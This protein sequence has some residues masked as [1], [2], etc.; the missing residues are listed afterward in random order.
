M[1]LMAVPQD[2]LDL[3]RDPA[4]AQLDQLLTNGGIGHVH[5]VTRPEF[6]VHD[7]A[8]QPSI[9]RVPYL[10]VCLEPFDAVL[11]PADRLTLAHADT[12]LYA[13][14][15]F[16]CFAL[17]ASQL[18]RLTF[19]TDY[20][21]LGKYIAPDL[22]LFLLEEAP[23]LLLQRLLEFTIGDTERTPLEM[24]SALN[25]IL[26][27][28]LQVLRGGPANGDRAKRS[29]LAVRSFLDHHY[30]SP[31]NRVTVARRFG[32]SE[33]HLSYLFERFSQTT[34]NGYLTSLRM[35]HAREMLLRTTMT[36]GEVANACGF[37]SANYFSRLYRRHHGQAPSEAGTTSSY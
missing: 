37:S 25:V 19:D 23:S 36:V 16:P 20:I 30:D 3:G 28:V 31:L 33:R 17:Q 6:P 1:G 2:E 15:T 21:L 24:R 18:L 4:I 34:F 7:F 9:T 8:I 22:S 27:E 12:L 35:E 14:G 10:I 26:G 13:P 29:Y 11:P 5:V 32:I